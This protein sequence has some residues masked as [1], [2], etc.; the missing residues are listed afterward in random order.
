MWRR[1]GRGD[2]DLMGEGGIELNAGRNNQQ[3]AAC[4]RVDFKE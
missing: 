4:D 1:N 3:S 2:A